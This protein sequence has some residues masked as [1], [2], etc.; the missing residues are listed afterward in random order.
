MKQNTEVLFEES[1]IT[2]LNNN[3]RDINSSKS[4]DLGRG[5]EFFSS[6]LDIF[7]KGHFPNVTS[8]RGRGSL[9]SYIKGDTVAYLF[10]LQGICGNYDIMKNY[11]DMKKYY[12]EKYL[13][14]MKEY[15]E[16]C[17]K[18]GRYYEEI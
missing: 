1:K 8:S 10:G 16:I 6:P 7:S 18:Y 12:C 4:Q 3:V 13:A 11:V 14:N 15:E 2:A 17:E 9:T 5:S